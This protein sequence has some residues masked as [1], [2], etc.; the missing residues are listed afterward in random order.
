MV[1]TLVIFQELLNKCDDKLLKFKQNCSNCLSHPVHV[2]RSS[3]HNARR[4]G[5]YDLLTYTTLC[6]RKYIYIYCFISGSFILDFF[7]I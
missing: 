5:Q 6:Y 2:S 7:I 3:M 4:Q 1:K